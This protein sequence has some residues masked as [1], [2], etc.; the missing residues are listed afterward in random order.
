[1]PGSR[2]R[3][4]FAHLL[5]DRLP[6]FFNSTSGQRLK[7]SDNMD[8]TKYILKRV[9]VSLIT[10]FIIIALTFF[11]MNLM[12]GDPFTGVKAVPDAIKEA[13]N[14]RYGLD[15]PLI[16]RFLLYI[17][18][19]MK[20]DFGMSMTF[21][22]RTVF[23][24]IKQAFPVSADLGI[25]SLIF[26]VTGGLLLGIY[27]ALRHNR[28]ADRISMVVAIIGV[29]LP[30]FI[31]GA[32]VQYFFG[33]QLSNFIKW[34]FNT[35]YQFLPIARWE[36]FTYT[37]LPSFAL[38]FGSLAIVARM[39][40][41]SM[42]DVI[43]QDYIKTAKAKGLSQQ[44]IIWKHMVRNAIL[45]IVTILGPMTAAILTGTFVIENIFA[46]PGLGKFFV[47]S[48]SRYDY[49]MTMG[50]TLFY[51]IFLVFMN[52]VVDISYGLIDPRIR[53]TKGRA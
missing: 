22:N 47:Q 8:L 51:A 41:T 52:L 14:K 36:G 53:L 49:T 39:M 46:I 7:W 17:W 34:A 6:P 44:A 35:N 33:Y 10:I 43:N 50:L 42:L 31:V 37:I 32:L 38:G 21:R 3:C 23:D 12:P 16:Q 19:I 20:G 28:K 24:I 26:G 9:W 13:L 1:M 18:N 40:R 4:C 15:K 48:V 2:R 27:A 25:R 11:L 5:Q 45:P 29:S 30:S